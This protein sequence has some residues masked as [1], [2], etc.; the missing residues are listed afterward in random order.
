MVQQTFQVTGMSCQHCI[1]AVSSEL[2]SI[3]GVSEVQVDLEAST[4]TVVSDNALDRVV[5]AAAIDA[6][7]YE[8]VP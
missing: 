3:A 4:A 1:D 2:S 5:V 6:A 8:L 7:G